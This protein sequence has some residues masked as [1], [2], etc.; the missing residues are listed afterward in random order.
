MSMKQY[1]QASKIRKHN[2][3]VFIVKD[4]SKDLHYRNF[5]G[6]DLEKAKASEFYDL[7]YEDISKSYLKGLEELAKKNYQAALDLFNKSKKEKVIKS[8]KPFSGTTTFKYYL[9]DKL[10]HCY[11]NL[12]EYKKADQLFSK[13]FKSGKH[14]AASR[15]KGTYIEY[16]VDQNLKENANEAFGYA[17][18]ILKTPRMKKELKFKL[19]LNRCLLLSMQRKARDARMELTRLEENY[20]GEIKGLKKQ[21]REAKATILIYHQKKY[22]DG[23]NLYEDLMQS[24]RKEASAETYLKLAYCYFNMKNYEDARWNYLQAFNLESDKLK[25]KN[26]IAKIKTVNEKI[27]NAE[28]NKNL[29][30]LMQEIE[31]TL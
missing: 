31:S 16:V 22:R 12:G 2:D 26:I 13:I 19:K 10:L 23:I 3:P 28:G 24:N 9:D 20:K 1:E 27:P 25:V 14:H 7:L 15:L 11:I 30:Q 6:G 29:N 21:M 8:Q 4:D 5:V 18:E 17:E